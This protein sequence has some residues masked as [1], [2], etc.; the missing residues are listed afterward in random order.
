MITKHPKNRQ[1]RRKL[2]EIK[3]KKNKPA[4]RQ[5]KQVTKEI[6]PVI[7]KI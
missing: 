7:Y 5:M 2:D 4:A 6:S 3:K 1:E